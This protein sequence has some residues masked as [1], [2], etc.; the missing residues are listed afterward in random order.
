MNKNYYI[1]F[2]GLFTL[3]MQS[4][5]VGKQYTRE[6][7]LLVQPDMFRSELQPRDT[8]TIA[9]IAWRDFFKDSVLNQYIQ[10]ALRENLDLKIAV[11]RIKTSQAYYLQAQSQ[12]F[13]TVTAA[14]EILYNSQS[15]NSPAG[16]ASGSRNE[17][18]QF[19]I[20]LSI[21]WEADIWGKISSAKR[22]SQASLLQTTASAQ[23]QQ[24]LLI[25]HVAKLYYQLLV[26]DAQYQILQ[27]TIHTRTRSLAT[28][29]ALK[30]A[31][32]LTE[33]A[34]QQSEAL[35]WNAKSLSLNITNQITITENALCILFNQSPH[36]LTRTRLD[37]Q[38]IGHELLYGVPYDLLKNRP[39]V[40]AAEYQLI[41]AFELSNVAAASFYPS[42]RIT[43]NT[44]LQSIDIDRL[45]SLKS[46]FVQTIASLTQPLWNKRQLKTQKEIALA[47]QQIAYLQYRQSILRAA[48][49]VSDALSI[50]QTQT[51]LM[52]LKKQEYNAYH[53]ATTYSQ[54]LVNYG[55]AN[56]LEVLRAQEYEL[57]AQMSYLNAHFG[58]LNAVVELYSA[59]GGGSR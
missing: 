39:D 8:G 32:I 2:F 49:E 6:Q 33:V 38:T 54:E 57:N 18:L 13:P 52:T 7:A 11:H 22:A 51:Q 47:N 20:P 55:M 50:Y 28:S 4:C 16:Q 29:Q 59:L 37:Q 41:S 21:G 35:L 5:F 45:F 15:L 31:G 56:Y 46:L 9:N 3:A 17:L 53:L 48:H 40:R 34:V 25:S 30:T 27:T 23:A 26:L 12:F 1:L 58:Q 36:A 24:S 19:G 42:L 43:A 44:G 10:L 14:P